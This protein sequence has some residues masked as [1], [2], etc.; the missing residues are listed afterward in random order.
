MI[1]LPLVFDISIGLIFIYLT[2]SLIASELQEYMSTV[3][4][5]RAKHLNNSI[6]SLL[7]GGSEANSAD[8]QNE[9]V[10][11]DG[12]EAN[13]ADLQNV[14]KLV[15]N[16]YNDPLI[17]TLNHGAS[18]II[19]KKMRKVTR[20]LGKQ[21]IASKKSAASYIPS[22][23]FTS[24]L[25]QTLKLPE[26]IQKARMGNG[27]SKENLSL[28]LAS[29]HELKTAIEAPPDSEEYKN[30][31]KVYGDVDHELK[32]IVKTLPDYVPHS[33]ITSLSA[34]AKRSQ[35]KANNL[36]EEL[37]QFR[38]EVET[39]F[40]RSMERA[41]GVYKRNSKGIALVI[42][43]I[44]AILT[45]TDTFH[46]ISRLSRDS[47]LRAGLTQY[48]NQ[49][50]LNQ[51]ASQE[52]NLTEFKQNLDQELDSVSLPIGWTVNNYCQQF[53]DLRDC[54]KRNEHKKWQSRIIPIL[55][56]ILGWIISG[57]AV[58]MG[59]PFWFQLLNKFINVRNTGS[60]PVT[61]TKDRP[62]SNS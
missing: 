57:I 28:I 49:A 51:N 15:E 5:W 16:L 3:L 12:N 22:E 20:I 24:T 46:V 7:S 41:S 9:S 42:G 1:N 56:T 27:E 48:A 2:L 45:N 26:L 52:N 23:T 32:T 36:D 6:E 14:K 44:L 60:K 61:Y 17:N 39:W 29:Y 62:S 53:D 21:N 40:D 33:V 58:S 43:F 59:A 37:N 13:S 35:F 55:R 30:I 25:L 54:T 34:L 10:L 47:A 19:E 11:S 8:L 31:K 38:Q 18:G 50:A 4:Q